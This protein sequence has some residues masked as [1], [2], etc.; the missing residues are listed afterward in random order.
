MSNPGDC[1]VAA[2]SEVARA[3]VGTE[4]DPENFDFWRDVIGDDIVADGIVYSADEWTHDS[5]EGVRRLTAS[6]RAERLA[7]ADPVP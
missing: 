4:A 2:Q 1:S 7:A 5:E 3:A 6:E